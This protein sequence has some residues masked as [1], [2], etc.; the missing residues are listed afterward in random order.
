MRVITENDPLC[1]KPIWNKEL[2]Y[3][4]KEYEKI[5]VVDADTMIRWDAPNIFDQF[6][7]DFCMVRDDVNW[8]WV[9]KSIKAYQ[10]F[11]PLIN[12]EIDNYGNA[13]VMFFH[14]KFLYIFEEVFNFYLLNKTELD[15]WD[16]GGG[17]E[18]TIFNYHLKKNNVEI[19][20]LSPAWNLLGLHKR[21]WFQMNSTVP[22]FLKYGYIWHFTGFPIEDRI[23]VIKNTWEAI[24]DDYS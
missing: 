13:G 3:K 9:H 20:W 18:Q 16:K 2:V 24:K 23:K 1:G 4:I 14:Q 11:F 15:S 19:K 22:H 7:E 10:E 21:G 17:R 12:L 5:G 8:S 6:S